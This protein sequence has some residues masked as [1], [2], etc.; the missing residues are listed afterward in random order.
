MGGDTPWKQAAVRDSWDADTRCQ[1]SPP[2]QAS[3]LVAD[4]AQASSWVAIRI[5]ALCA[6]NHVA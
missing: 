3:H 2:V 5:D 4:E 1:F 6:V